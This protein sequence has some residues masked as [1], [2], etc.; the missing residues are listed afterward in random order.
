MS[1]ERYTMW[2]QLIVFYLS[3]LVS[4][5][6][7][8]SSICSQVVIFILI[9]KDHHTIY[10]GIHNRCFSLFGLVGK[11]IFG[12]FRYVFGCSFHLGRHNP[13]LYLPGTP[14]AMLIYIVSVRAFSSFVPTAKVWFMPGHAYPDWQEC[15]GAYGNEHYFGDF[16]ALGCQ[17][18]NEISCMVGSRNR[19]STAGTAETQQV[20]FLFYALFKRFCHIH[21]ICSCQPGKAWLGVNHAF[22]VGANELNALTESMYTICTGAYE[23]PWAVHGLLIGNRQETCTCYSINYGYN[24]NLPLSTI[25]Y[26][27][28]YTTSPDQNQALNFGRC[29]QVVSKQIC[30]TCLYSYSGCFDLDCC[31][32]YTDKEAKTIFDA[33]EDEDLLFS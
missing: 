21:A 33:D 30:L 14:V 10:L 29:T 1:R 9:A 31:Y 16:Q 11:A 18:G 20:F 17:P 6:T 4:W 13:I 23:C 26:W 25:P 7:T 24:N 2:T 5:P 27:M 15:T 32:S 12:A 19:E 22:A 3:L 28:C 8:C